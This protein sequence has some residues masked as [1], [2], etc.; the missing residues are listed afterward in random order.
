MTPT[1]AQIWRHPVKGVGAEPL[2][3]V[4]LTPGRPLPLDR[5]WAILTGDAQDTGAWQQCRNFARGCYGPGLMAVTAQCKGNRITFSHPDLPDLTIDPATEGAALVN[6]ITPIYA[7]E[8]PQ[9][10]QMIAAPETGMADVD[11]ASVSIMGLSSL[12]ALGDKIGQPL[13]ARRFRGN[14]WVEGLAPF[15]ELAWPGATI[16][17]G[18][19]ELTVEEPITRCRATEA[20]PNTGRR[21]I[22]TLAALRDGWDH[23]HFGVAARVTKPGRIAAGDKV[24]AP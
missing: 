19:A 17:I 8:R 4:D 18:D 2:E 9:P 20:N 12:R 24:T 1:L 15:E 21:D 6:W 5:A 14:L 3:L 16:G 11:Y 13:D 22:N 7:P 23:T 10:T